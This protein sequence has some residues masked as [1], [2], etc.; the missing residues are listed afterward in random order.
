MKKISIAVIYGGIS[1][2]HEVSLTSAQSLMAALDPKKYHVL[3]VRIRKNGRWVIDPS[4]APIAARARLTAG[5]RTLAPNGV[6]RGLTTKDGRAAEK[7]DVVFPLVHGTGGEDGCLQGLLELAGIPYVGSGVLGSAVGMDK[8]I[9]KKILEREGFPIVRYH[10]FLSADW[11]R[12]SQAIVATIE[13]R[14]GYPCFVKPANLGSSV[15]VSKAHH[16]KELRQG[17]NEALVYDRKIIVERGV[18]EAREIECAVI[19][20]DDPQASI[21]GEI[22]PSNEFYDYAAK[23]I[24][25]N[26]RE[27]IPADLPKALATK[28]RTMAI[29]A[30]RVTDVSGMARVDFFVRRDTGDIYVNELNTIPGFTRFSMFPKLWAATGLAYPELLDELVRLALERAAEKRALIRSFAPPRSKK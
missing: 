12:D 1:G 15:G 17:V 27:I 24:D 13:K 20:N 30:F 21:L 14:L 28:I 25:G 7:I 16:R 19:G 3:P 5:E 4:L 29:K 2:E 6:A 18:P 26:S 11:K 10:H 8:V 23:Y 9:E 22:V